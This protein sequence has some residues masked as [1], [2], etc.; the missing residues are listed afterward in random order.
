MGVEYC[1]PELH[2]A[3]TIL[4]SHSPANRDILEKTNKVW[5][6]DFRR[7]K[8]NPLRAEDTTP[9]STDQDYDNKMQV[10]MN[11]PKGKTNRRITITPNLSAL[12]SFQQIE[13]LIEYM[14]TNLEVAVPD[15]VQQPSKWGPKPIVQTPASTIFAKMKNATTTSPNIAPTFNAPPNKQTTSSIIIDEEATSKATTGQ[16]ANGITTRGNSKTKL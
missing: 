1:A 4:S 14:E 6:L 5:C 10:L 13:E 9:Q 2:D 11:T 12:K 15:N 16:A 8:N 3:L 7:C